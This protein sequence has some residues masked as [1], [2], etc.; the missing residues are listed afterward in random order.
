MKTKSLIIILFMI[1]SIKGISQG[2]VAKRVDNYSFNLAFGANFINSG[3]LSPFNEVELDFK[4]PFFITAERSITDNWTASLTLATNKLTINE[5]SA[6]NYYSADVLANLY[7]DKLLFNNK[8]FNLYIGLGGGINKIGNTTKTN[9]NLTGG[10][11]YWFS[12]RVGVLINM[13]GKVNK[14]SIEGVKNHYQLNTGLVWR[15]KGKNPIVKNKPSL[16]EKNVTS[17]LKSIEDLLQSEAKNKQEIKNTE[18]ET[19]KTIN[20]II[21]SI[22]VTIDTSKKEIIKDIENIN[23]KTINYIN[24]QFIN[25]EKIN[26]LTSL[27]DTSAVKNGYYI[28]VH[29]LY[30][31]NNIDKLEKDLKKQNIPIQVFQNHRTKKY[32]VS[33]AYFQTKKEAYQYRKSGLNKNLFKDSWVHEQK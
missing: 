2:L 23:I 6:K 20:K 26:I 24:K 27:N 18:T 22:K 11:R 21:D 16:F 29:V 14:T 10:F 12:P 28:I 1:I 7:L 30:N 15:I 19:Q 5:G 13:I 32:Y 9:F 8:D 3:G 17:R 25:K 33:V 31:K 4:T